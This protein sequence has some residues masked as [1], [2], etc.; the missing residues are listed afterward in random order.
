MGV[1]NQ[2]VIS[3]AALVP[4]VKEK[5]EQALRRSAE[6]DASRITVKSVGGKVVLSGTV[7]AWYE[8]GIAERA[9]W[10]APGVIDVQDN[11]QIAP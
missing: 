8:R 2:I 4:E 7:H 1:L 6:L 9:A 11:I 5:I 10:S 3:S